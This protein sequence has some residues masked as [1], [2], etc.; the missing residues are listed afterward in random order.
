MITIFI[1]ALAGA[2]PVASPPAKSADLNKMVCKRQ[3]ETGSFV[4][5]RK[6]CRTRAEWTRVRETAQ[7][8]G[9]GMQSLVST[10]R[11]N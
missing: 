9:R 6:V 8:T 5:A 2:A 7:E 3:A 10:E 11:G 1:A 4:K